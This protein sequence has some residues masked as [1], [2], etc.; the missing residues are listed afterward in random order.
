MLPQSPCSGKKTFHAEM[1]HKKAKSTE[2]IMTAWSLKVEKTN[3]TPL[4]RVA[5][6]S[7]FCFHVSFL[8]LQF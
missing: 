4:I 2:V 3:I 1:H 6:W 7:D 8:K 5:I